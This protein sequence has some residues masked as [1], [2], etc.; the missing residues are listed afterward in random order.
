MVPGRSL[1]HGHQLGLWLKQDH[2]PQHGPWWQHSPQTSTC[3]QV[4]AQTRQPRP[5]V[6]TCAI[7]SMPSSCSRTLGPDMFQGGST[8]HRHQ[9]GSTSLHVSPAPMHHFVPLSFPPL[10]CKFVCHSGVR[11]CSVFFCLNIFTCKYPLP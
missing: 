2:K 7:V 3:H 1:V 6:V 4:A 11:N 5:P 9:H 10:H 8:D